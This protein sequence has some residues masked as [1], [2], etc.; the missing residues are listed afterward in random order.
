MAKLKGGREGENRVD[1]CK[2]KVW[3]GKGVCGVVEA[4]RRMQSVF[5]AGKNWGQEGSGYYELLFWQVILF[6][7]S[8][9]YYSLTF[10][11]IC[12]AHLYLKHILKINNKIIP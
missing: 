11:N 8:L 1:F 9:R 10:M 2:R 3:T 5:G 7:L 6:I 12:T 4:G